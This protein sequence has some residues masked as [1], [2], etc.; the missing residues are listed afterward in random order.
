MY[1]PIQKREYF[2]AST[3][4]CLRCIWRDYNWRPYWVFI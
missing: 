1:K 3:Y 2:I 4:I